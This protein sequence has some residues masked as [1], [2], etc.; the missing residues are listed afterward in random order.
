[1]RANEK[2]GVLQY[3]AENWLLLVALVAGGVV[4][5]LIYYI[6]HNGLLKSLGNALFG[7]VNSDAPGVSGFVSRDVRNL[8]SDGITDSQAKQFANSLYYAMSS[9]GTDDKEMKH[10]YDS[11]FGK[12][13]GVIRVYNA[14][15]THKYGTFGEPFPSWLGGD[16]LDLV[17]WLR[18]EL[19]GQ[20]LVDWINLLA[21]VGIG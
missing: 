15:G 7:T 19:S 14:F 5:Y 11:L 4:V 8:P 20:L 17:G 1:M 13:A 18:R 16:D 10:I 6:F 2:K 3:L 12:K 21:S 9:A